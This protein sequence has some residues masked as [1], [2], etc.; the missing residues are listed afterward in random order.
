MILFL[1]FISHK[2]QKIINLNQ[3]KLIIENDQNKKI[4]LK[5]EINKAKFKSRLGYF[6]IIIIAISKF[7]IFTAAWG[8]KFNALTLLIILSYIIVA[9]IHIN[10]SGYFFS[11]ISLSRNLKRDFD[12]YLHNST[13]SIVTHYIE[14]FKTPIELTPAQAG[15]QSLILESDSYIIK[16]WGILYDN[17]IQTL[18]NM[19]KNSQ[20]KDELGK[21][22]LKLQLRILNSNQLIDNDKSN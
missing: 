11:N 4:I 3:N 2:P 15:N 22:C 19:Q 17:E 8:F 10:N 6:G 21:H 5:Q 13:N 16:S 14:T 12:N 7:L 20:A 1:A 9:Y 18:L